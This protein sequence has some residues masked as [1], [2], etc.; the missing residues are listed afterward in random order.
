MFELKPISKKS[1][2]GVLEKAERY[3]LLNEPLEA[4]SICLDVLE[5]DDD[6]QEALVTLLLALTDQF[7]RKLTEK[8][9]QARE[10]LPKLEDDYTRA[11]YDGIIC[12]RRAKVS[13]Q[14]GGPG[15]GNL[16]YDWFRQ[17]MDR[18]EEAA[19]HKPKGNEDA[20]LRWNTCA[21]IL[22][23][24]PHVIPLVEEQVQDMLE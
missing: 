19:E 11:Y 1:I 16:A 5:I 9:R 8:F 21:R 14:Q 20:T 4:E 10:I 12:E 24:N 23:R 22:N 18:Y 6:N 7:G 13:L 2:P 3:R 15:S 17:A